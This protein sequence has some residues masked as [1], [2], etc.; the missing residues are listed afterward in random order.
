[1]PILA[2]NVLVG[3]STLDLVSA[4]EGDGPEGRRS[5]LLLIGAIVPVILLI[6]YLAKRFGPRLA[7]SGD[8]DNGSQDN[9]GS[10]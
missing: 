1:L 6:L 9:L 4:V 2:V 10:E 7:D 3:A 5:P 8:D